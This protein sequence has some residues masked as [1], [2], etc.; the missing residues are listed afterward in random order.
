MD[1]R[2]AQPCPPQLLPP[3]ASLPFLSCQVIGSLMHTAHRITDFP[4]NLLLVRRKLMG[5]VS[6]EQP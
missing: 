4:A 1:P 3:P 5:Q 2:G 6:E